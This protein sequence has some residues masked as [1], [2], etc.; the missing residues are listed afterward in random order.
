MSHTINLVKSQ[1][2]RRSPALGETL[3]C[4]VVVVA[5][6]VVVVV[7]VVL[8]MLLN[9]LRNSYAHIQRLVLPSTLARKAPLCCS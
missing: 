5:V 8:D 1:W 3:Y 7:V 6:V 2:P 9:H 4:C